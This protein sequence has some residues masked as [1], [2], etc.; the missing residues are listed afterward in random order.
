MRFSKVD[1]EAK[2]TEGATGAGGGTDAAGA[3]ASAMTTSSAGEA[4]GGEAPSARGA[5]ASSLVVL[6]VAVAVAVA[7]AVGGVAGRDAAAAAAFSAE[8]FL[9]RF[10]CCV[11]LASSS[12]SWRRM[13]CE[14]EIAWGRVQSATNLHGEP[15]LRARNVE[16]DRRADAEALHEVVDG[17]HLLRVLVRRSERG[18][19]ELEVLE[20]NGVALGTGHCQRWEPCKARAVQLTSS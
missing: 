13:R 1:S 7:V 12:A 6:V 16:R 15:V 2:R 17:R 20:K 19:E 4:E 5:L 8:S 3:T 9:T 18:R 10:S 11:L 14:W